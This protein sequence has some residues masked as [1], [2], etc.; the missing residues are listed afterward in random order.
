LSKQSAQT[1]PTPLKKHGFTI[2]N[3]GRK[4]TRAFILR[5]GRAVALLSSLPSK[6]AWQ[7]AFAS[8]DIA[9]FKDIWRRCALPISGVKLGKRA[10]I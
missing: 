6:P 3:T 10:M 7:T 1:F 4:D 2:N 9:H 8:A 5:E